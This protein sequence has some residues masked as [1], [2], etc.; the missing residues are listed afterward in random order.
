MKSPKK[1][2]AFEKQFVKV[3]LSGLKKKELYFESV[4]PVRIP[5][6]P[7]ACKPITYGGLISALNVKRRWQE[8]AYNLEALFIIV[9]GENNNSFFKAQKKIGTDLVMHY[10]PEKIIETSLMMTLERN[11]AFW[12][13][14]ATIYSNCCRL[15]KWI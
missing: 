7:T 14:V 13:L 15:E 2:V 1:R 9:F 11:D 3:S 6:M 4:R 8:A 5:L 12:E 10:H